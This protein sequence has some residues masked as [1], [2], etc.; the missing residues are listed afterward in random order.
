MKLLNSRSRLRTHLAAA[1][2]AHERAKGSLP[3]IETAA[4]RDAFVEQLVDSVRRVEYVSAAQRRAISSARRDP[5]SDLFDPVLGAIECRNAGE[6]EE[7]LWLL[8]LSVHCGKHLHDGWSLV[9][10]LYEGDGSGGKWTWSRVS[11]NPSAFR[12]WLDDKEIEWQKQGAKPR[13]GN[14]RKYVSLS[15]SGA[16]GTGAAV[17]TYV[18]AMGP[19]GSQRQWVDDAMARQDGDPGRAFDDLYRSLSSVQQFGRLAKFDFLCMLGKCGLA[20]IAPRH[21]YLGDSTGP[22]Q[23]ARLLFGVNGPA[24]DR[25]AVELGASLGVGMQVIEDALCNWGKSPARYKRFRG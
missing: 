4:R 16:R 15:G 20:N 14:H 7:A 11:K 3:G 6:L 21:A 24:L 1:L 22:L 23:G 2:A 5:K 25:A 19:A 8:F 17:E 9:R 12:R 13:F 10:K 18:L